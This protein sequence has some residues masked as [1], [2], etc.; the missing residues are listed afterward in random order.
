LFV[1]VGNLMMEAT[2]TWSSVLYTVACMDLT[3]AVLAI[4]ALRPTLAKHVAY[5]SDLL[6]R[7]QAAAAAGQPAPAV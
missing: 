7:E 4:V 6:K 3:A 1:P 5:S 2:G